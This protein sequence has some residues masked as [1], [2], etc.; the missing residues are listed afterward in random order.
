MQNNT[1]T[2]DV[3][4]TTLFVSYIS[5]FFQYGIAFLVLPILLRELD[6]QTVGVWYLFLS[7]HSL[8]SLLDF[9]FGP[10]VQRSF[11]YVFAGA[12]SLYADGYDSSPDK[13]LNYNLINSLLYTCKFIYKRISIFIFL[14]GS[15]I[16][17][18]YLHH[19][20]KNFFDINIFF[21]WILYIGTTALYFYYCYFL[22]VI[23]GR[24][25]ITHYNFIVISSK[26]IYVLSLFILLILNCGLL[27]LIVANFL[28][29]IVIII[30]G[31]RLYLSNVDKKRLHNCDKP[32]NLYKIIWK[33]ARNSGLVSLGVFL[34]S[35]AGIFLSGMFLN[36][37][38]VA[39][40]GLL[41]QVFGIIVVLSRVNINTVLPKISSLWVSGT[42][43]EIRQIFIKN[44]FIGYVIYFICV[45]FLFVLGNRVLA[46]INS[47]VVL[48]SND[49]ILLYALFYL[50]ELTHG[51][52]C[53]LIS[54]SNNIP[55]VKASIISGVIAII[56]SLVFLYLKLGMISFPLGLICGSLPYNSWKWPVVTYKILK[57]ER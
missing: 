40:L 13:H 28:N 37:T 30:I 50:M 55:F 1:S 12:K 21:I 9:G 2:F 42:I 20:L 15:T 56:T 27:S 36:L 35:Q 44:Q 32:E 41:L 25:N 57:Q 7:I 16:G 23:R 11:S 18:L 19:S 54:S 3:N 24:G 4:K 48:P 47:N 22:S 8:V 43:K 33:N 26:S 31:K 17:S 29:I 6:A 10:S 38:E 51:N 53:T 14:L 52:C 39:Q 49:V 34:L 45:L 5:Q 46:L